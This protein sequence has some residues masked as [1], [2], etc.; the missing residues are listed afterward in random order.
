MRKVLNKM[1]KPLLIVTII[2]L[3]FGLLM[4]GSASSLKA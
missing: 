4:V 2:C 3:I 1:D